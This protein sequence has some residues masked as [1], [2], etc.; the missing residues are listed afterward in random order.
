VSEF[1]Q[2]LPALIG[3]LIGAAGSYLVTSVN[4]RARWRREQSRRWDPARLQA[5]VDYG[6]AV[7][8]VFHLA[9]RIAAYRGLHTQMSPL[10]SGEGQALLE[11]AA[12]E[13]TAKW[14]T[15]LLLGDPATIAAARAW[16]VS[17]WRLEHF[18]KGNAQG[19]EQWN[20]AVAEAGVKRQR[21][22]EAARRD[23]GIGGVPPSGSWSIATAGH[24]PEFGG[25]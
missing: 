24:E 25:P 1:V 6:N 12:Q 23:L 20:A 17:V 15:V 4:E 13:R 10:A 8:K 11:A 21:Y 18:A 22:Y 14:E 16:H 5:Y 19:T 2:Q 9:A 7:K 3:V